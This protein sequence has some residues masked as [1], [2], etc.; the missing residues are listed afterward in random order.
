M[1]VLLFLLLLLLF[2]KGSRA[3]EMTPWVKAP[4][5]KPDDLSLSLRTHVVGGEN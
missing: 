5:T 4:G 1:T 2:Y 3:I